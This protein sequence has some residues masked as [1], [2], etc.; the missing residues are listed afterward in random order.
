VTY[1]NFELRRVWKCNSFSYFWDIYKAILEEKPNVVHIQHE[2]TIYGGPFKSSLFPILLLL[3]K[4]RGIPTVVEMHTVLPSKPEKNFFT[5]YGV[6]PTLGHIINL[7]VKAVTWFMGLFATKLTVH[8]TPGLEILTN[9]YQIKKDKV[10]MIPLPF[11]VDVKKINKNLAKKKLGFQNKKI[12]L[13]FGFVKSGKGIEYL[14]E[15]MHKVI[16]QEKNAFLVIAGRTP[17]ISK[18]EAES[19]GANIKEMIKNQNLNKYVLFKNEFI[20]KEDIPV[21]FSAADV[22]VLPYIEDIAGASAVAG[23]GGA[24]GVPVVTSTIAR[25]KGTLTDGKNALMVPPKDEAALAEAIIKILKH[26]KMALSIGKNLRDW[27]SK[28]SWET[29][30]QKTRGL[31]LDII[32]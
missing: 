29:I 5:S 3:L 32:K 26:P 4:L 7:G 15:S 13:F 21:Y 14:I 30:S 17:T 2:Y 12:V 8:N 1:K 25:F 18:K 6:S 24:Y 27:V 19:Y 11:D 31:F 22:F 9:E 16:K 23:L 10:Q 20:P 28:N